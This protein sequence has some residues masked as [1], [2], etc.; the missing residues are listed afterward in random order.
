MQEGGYTEAAYRGYNFWESSDG[1]EAS[2]TLA[3]DG[4]LINRD[5]EAVVAVLRRVSR[6]SDSGLPWNDDDGELQ[7]VMALTG[8][9]LVTTAGRDC[10]LADNTGCRAAAWAF[11]RGEERRTVIE[12]AAALLFR[13]AASAASAA[14]LI[15]QAINANELMALTEILT[16]GATIT[17]GADIDRDDFAGLEAPVGTGAGPFHSWVDTVGIHPLYHGLGLRDVVGDS[18]SSWTVA[19]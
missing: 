3:E 13:N 14:P 19:A 5:L 10:R 6:D 17:V 11:S 18:N 12:G 2:A 8:E 7:Q 9:E 16:T 15:E 4:F 1:S